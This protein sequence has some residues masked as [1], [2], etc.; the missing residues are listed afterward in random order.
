MNSVQVQIIHVF[1]MSFQIEIFGLDGILTPRNVFCS[2][3]W[4]FRL[5]SMFGIEILRQIRKE[6]ENY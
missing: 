4:K 6:N 1:E 5:V 2:S 3:G